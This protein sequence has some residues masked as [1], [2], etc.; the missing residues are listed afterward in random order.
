[1]KEQ[2]N[3]KEPNFI[4]LTQLFWQQKWTI[5]IVT[6]L[7]T[8]LSFVYTFTHQITY[9]ARVLLSVPPEIESSFL[10]L[11]TS[12]YP[13]LLKDNDFNNIELYSLFT[14]VL[15]SE[16]IKQLFATE[17]NNLLK[18][19]RVLED[20]RTN[21]SQFL[22]RFTAKDPEEAKKNLK[23]YIAYVNKIAL[24]RLP[25][26][27]QRRK[28]IILDK[29]NQQIILLKEVIK[30]SKAVYTARIKESLAIA[31]QNGIKNIVISSPGIAE[32]L[33]QIYEENYK[34]HINQIKSSQFTE[35]FAFRSNILLTDNSIKS[36]L[37]NIL[38]LGVLGG[39]VLG[40]FI[41]MIREGALPLSN[42]KVEF[43]Q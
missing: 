38:L 19:I 34:L 33:I 15:K 4:N 30:N 13:N 25:A 3:I 1:M 31:E 8:L 26:L 6:M 5:L 22:V 29:L 35:L 23:A 28:E 18:N 11:E 17:S 32:E 42:R 27:V 39:L 2:Y 24:S 9:E 10:N 36:K 14:Q 7:I 43:Y 41:A 12:I 40:F 37:F 21:P 16:S 20:K